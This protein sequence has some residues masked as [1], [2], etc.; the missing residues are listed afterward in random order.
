MH[1]PRLLNATFEALW[2]LRFDPRG[3]YLALGMLS[4]YVLVVRLE[5]GELLVDERRH[6]GRVWDLAFTPDGTN[7]VSGGD[8]GAV[9]IWDLR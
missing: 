5:D 9:L 2:C 7:L 4:G 8:D 3:R 6:E 1:L